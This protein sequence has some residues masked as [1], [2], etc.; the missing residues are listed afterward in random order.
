LGMAPIPV[1]DDGH[2]LAGH[3]DEISVDGE[4]RID[5]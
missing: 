2:S 4:I 5:E 3:P 1:A